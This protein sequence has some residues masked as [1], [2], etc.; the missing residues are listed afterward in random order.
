MTTEIDE[1]V[2]QAGYQSGYQSSCQ[3]SYQPGSDAGTL[4]SVKSLFR[5]YHRPLLAWL[6]QRLAVADDADDVAQETWI[7]LMKY[8]G[9]DNILCHKSMLYKVAANVAIDQE[10]MGKARRRHLHSTIDEDDDIPSRAPS[11][12]QIIES[13]DSYQFILQK[14]EKLPPRCRQ[15]FLLSRTHAMTYP[16]I[17]AHCNISVKM[18]E[19]H[20]SH[21]LLVLMQLRA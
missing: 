14:I 12:E 9:V 15:V 21:A 8:E 3:S 6:R 19:K 10:R 17:A 13:A 2:Y 20:I 11:V 16:Q 18:V 7:R 1:T 4:L 5:Q